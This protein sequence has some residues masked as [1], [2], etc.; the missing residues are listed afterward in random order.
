MPP[1]GL[2]I[3]LALLAALMTPAA[4]QE[5]IAARAP[6]Y[7]QI[8]A[9]PLPAPFDAI[10]DYEAEAQGSYLLENVPAGETVEDWSQMLTLSGAEGAAAGGDAAGLAEAVAGH[11]LDGYSA[12]CAHP[13]SARSFEAPAGGVARDS[14]LAWIG[15][16]EV[17]GAG[18]SE[19]MALLVLVGAQDIY[20]LQWAERGPARAALEMEARW[21]DRL[22]LLATTGLCD[23]VAGEEA[24][25]P[26]CDP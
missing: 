21:T 10:P 1:P 15:C 12:A 11:F 2:P 16:A 4:A 17:A 5:V 3:S 14:F 26:S 19:E 18:R 22:K 9:F 24:P 20:T 7:D 6:V 23:P 8:V 25:Y 13:V